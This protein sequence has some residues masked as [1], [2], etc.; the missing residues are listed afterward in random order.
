M[1]ISNAKTTQP[2]H[3]LTNLIS[4]NV[5]YHAQLCETKKLSIISPPNS[6]ILDKSTSS[7]TSTPSQSISTTNSIQSSLESTPSQILMSS[8][9]HKS[10]THYLEISATTTPIHCFGGLPNRQ[11]SSP[12]DDSFKWI[13]NKQGFLDRVKFKPDLC[14]IQLDLE[15]LAQLKSE[16]SHY[17]STIE[18]IELLQM[19]HAE[20]A[21]LTGLVNQLNREYRS[22]CVGAK[23]VKGNLESLGE[24]IELVH[25]ELSYIGQFEDSELNRDWSAPG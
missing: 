1:T 20:T 23:T 14:Q 15:L 6:L 19:R 5:Q 22:L 8:H 7:N 3:F 2:N 21:E 11:Q 25:E 18:S 24:Y 9:R 10:T 16:L 12:I 13:R 17:R 4:T